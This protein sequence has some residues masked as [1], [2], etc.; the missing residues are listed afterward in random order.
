MGNFDNDGST[1]YEYAEIT[2]QLFYIPYDTNYRHSLL[3]F[4][5]CN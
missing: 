2:L 1:G 5:F 3:I 4:I